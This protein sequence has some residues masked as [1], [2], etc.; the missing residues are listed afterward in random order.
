MPN[1]K[2]AGNLTHMNAP[3]LRTLKRVSALQKRERT[4]KIRVLNVIIAKS[5]NNI[6]N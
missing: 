5:D 6:S 3:T 1:C 4:Q 2:A